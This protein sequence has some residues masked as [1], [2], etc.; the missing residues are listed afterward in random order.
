[1]NNR[2]IIVQ[3]NWFFWITGIQRIENHL[4]SSDAKM[5][6][7]REVQRSLEEDTFQEMIN[8]V[9]IKSIL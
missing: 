7:M 3:S 8:Y 4:Q 1:M 2:R 6:Q 5:E 9:Q